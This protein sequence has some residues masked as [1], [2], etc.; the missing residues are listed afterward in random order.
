MDL[1]FPLLGPDGARASREDAIRPENLQCVCVALCVHASPHM[2]SPARAL[3]LL[4]TLALAAASCLA[5]CS[6]EVPPDEAD[7]GTDGDGNISEDELVSER[8]IMGADMAQKHLALTFDDGPGG[9]TAEL[10]NYLGDQGIPAAFF[11]NGKNVPGRQNVLDTII[12]RGHTLAN[13]TQN[14][15]QMTR[16]S[17][18]T[19]FKAVADTDAHILSV[20]PA[21]PSLLRAPYGAWNGRVA[22][23][24]NGTSMKKYVGSIF[25]DV[26][27]TLTSTAAADWDCWGRGV[28]VQRC[29]DLYLQEIRSKKRGIVLL[30]DVHS[31]TV[32]M[33]KLMVPTLKAEGYVFDK[34]QDAPA[35]KRAIANVSATPATPS[36]G[37]ATTCFSSTLGTNQPENACVQSARDSRWYRCSGGE[38]VAS[39][40]TDTKCTSRPR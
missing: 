15:A 10:A 24:L 22:T 4:P 23:E 3:R 37:A 27:G 38:W 12:R 1:W 7:L 36:G 32:D 29:A 13:H 30:H 28:T 31:K 8:Q 34:L 19:L 9:R 14:H 21:G 5:A 35:V 26:G 18:D 33:V 11:I 17:G 16:I 20:Q 39:S 40:E 2:V 6:A 25:W